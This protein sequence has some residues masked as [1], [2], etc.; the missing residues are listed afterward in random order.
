MVGL[1]NRCEQI[2]RT[3]FPQRKDEPPVQI[4]SDSAQD[5]YEEV[6]E[7]LSKR[8]QEIHDLQKYRGVGRMTYEE[9]LKLIPETTI[10][11][12]ERCSGHA[13][14]YGVKKAHHDMA[15]KII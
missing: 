11:T 9:F 1:V 7:A 2:Q 15:M 14:T 13:G 4:M 5:L 3:S 10:N 12:V 6:L 8:N